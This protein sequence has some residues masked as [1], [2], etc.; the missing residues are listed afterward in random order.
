MNYNIGAYII[1][2]VLM[3]V[4]IVVA[5]K[6]FFTNGRVFCHSLLAQNTA[7]GDPINKLLLVAYYLFNIGYAFTKLQ[8]WQKIDSLEGLFSSLAA[9]MGTLILILAG[10]HYFNMVAI[11]LL[12]RSKLFS[13]THK[14]FHL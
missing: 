14:S 6:Y 4:I 13:I 2:L 11:Y 5:G 10:T 9:N 8:H 1:F 3:V 7:L 12:S